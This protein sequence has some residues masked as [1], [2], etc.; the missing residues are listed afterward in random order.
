MVLTYQKLCQKVIF[1]RYINKYNFLVEFCQ[2]LINI[3]LSLE[4]TINYC[5]IKARIH[6]KVIA[7][8]I[9][10]GYCSS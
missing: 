7:I 10:Y 9:G 8:S 5:W 4:I 2:Q 1:K 6:E 3:F